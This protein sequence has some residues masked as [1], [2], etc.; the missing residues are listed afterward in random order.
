MPSYQYMNSH[1]K[2][3]TVSQP[4]HI[5]NGNPVHAKTVLILKQGPTYVAKNIFSCLSYYNTYYGRGP[6][7]KWCHS[8]IDDDIH[9]NI[10]KLD[11]DDDNYN[12]N[13]DNINN[14][15]NNTDSVNK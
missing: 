5:Y 12:N 4:S 8:I 14:Q 13:N 9:N 6:F 1:Y 3:K 15:K 10:G 2:E 11:I 7:A